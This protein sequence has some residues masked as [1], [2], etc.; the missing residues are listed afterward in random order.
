M[1][2][3]NDINRAAARW[4]LLLRTGSPG[5][6][7]QLIQA[8]ASYADLTQTQYAVAL[9]W[10]ITLG[11]APGSLEPGHGRPQN[12]L[13]G[14]AP[15]Q[16][17]QLLFERSLAIAMPPWLPDADFLIPDP[18][19]LPLDA[20]NLARALGLPEEAAFRGILKIHGKI[21]LQRRAAVGLAGELALVRLLEGRWPGSTT[22]VALEDDGFGYDIAFRYAGVEWHL[23]V[24]ATTRRGRL[25]IYLS[26]HEFEVG[27]R[28]PNWRLV[29]LGLNAQLELQALGT[30]A[31]S[32]LEN[33]API[34][35]CPGTQWQSVLLKL[36]PGDLLAG[37]S[38]LMK[39]HGSVGTPI[40]E[41]LQG[42][43]AFSWLPQPEV[44]PIPA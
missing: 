25:A 29:T 5:Q 41:H 30:V 16:C 43:E 38:L 21:D 11:L 23:E 26:R 20:A 35:P 17:L 32:T 9:D 12:M 37:L 18:S 36:G 15:S 1:L 33:R 31:N 14:L 28:D 4:C 3:A 39:P 44:R 19:E 10:L 22:H 7:W 13:Q 27:M 24:K 40:G 42:Q 6:A 2:P 34:D 8:D